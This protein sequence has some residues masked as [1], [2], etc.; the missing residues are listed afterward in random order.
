[1]KKQERYQINNLN[2]QLKEIEKEQTKS[3]AIKEGNNRDKN[4]VKN[5]TENRKAIKKINK[6]KN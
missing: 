6:T 5:I 1:M 2:L 4:K 3:K